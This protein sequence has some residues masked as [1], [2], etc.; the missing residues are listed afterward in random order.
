MGALANMACH[1]DTVGVRLLDDFDILRLCRS[2][3][4]HENDARVLLE[5]TR[6]LN[7]MLVHSTSNQII[8]E[9]QHLSSFF[10]PT[11]MTPVVFHQYTQII[12][13]TLH[14]ELL[15]KSLEFT[16]RAVVYINAITHSLTHRGDRNAFIPKD[17]AI[18]LMK[19]G[20]ER[21]DE[22]GR[23]VGI[24]MGFNRLVAKNVMHLLWA[25]MAYG[26]VTP[27]ECGKY[28]TVTQM[29]EIV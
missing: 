23:G 11:P 22:E 3:L 21:L 10:E 6:L 26:L 29:F 15:L 25:L 4:W 9:H 18:T 14:A 17:D 20:T 7:T 8:L 2:I 13:N 1:W 12:C 27:N 24:G 16:T 5:T 19:W 28:K